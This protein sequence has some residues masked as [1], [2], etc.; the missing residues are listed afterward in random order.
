LLD[1]GSIEPGIVAIPRADRPGWDA[2]AL[3][4]SFDTD[5]WAR[6]RGLSFRAVDFTVLRRDDERSISDSDIASRHDEDARRQWLVARLR[7][8]LQ[9]ARGTSAILLGAW[10]G[11]SEPRAA[12]IGARVGVPV[13][14]ALV[15]IGSP[16]GLRFAAARDRLLQKIGAA[17]V[18]GW[19][20]SVEA[21]EGALAVRLS[22]GD[23][24]RARRVV[25]AIGGVA[26]GG[27]VYTPPDHEADEDLPPAG[28][29]AFSPSLAAPVQLAARGVQLDVVGSMHGPDMDDTAWPAP[30]VPGILECVGL[31]CHG[32][33]AAPRITSAGDAIAD[34]PRTVLEAVASGIAAGA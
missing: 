1:L 16:A 33:V 28:S 17:T 32:V 26:G 11:A 10:L 23:V 21:R 22:N 20:E 8:H 2:D 30:A 34:R 27:I 13:G 4:D 3:A 24:L 9:R 15:A 5:P 6:E 12:E 18:D 31:K 7:F 19:A 14:E 29:R 25:L